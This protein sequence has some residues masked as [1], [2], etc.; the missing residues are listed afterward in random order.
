MIAI[1]SDAH[2]NL[3]AL[4]AV[5]SDISQRS[6]K[7]KIFL[8]DAVG[9]GPDPEPVLE[10][11]MEQCSILVQGNHDRAVIDPELEE[12]FNDAA[13]EAIL[14]TRSVMSERAKGF[15][16]NLPLT[17]SSKREGIDIFLVHASPRAPE[18]WNYILTLSDAHRNFYYFQEKLCFI[19]HS[20]Y[21]FVVEMTGSRQI[22]VRY[23]R[24]CK[25]NRDSRYIINA[26]SVGQP[27][28][29]D[30]RACYV[31]FNGTEV[32]F[33]RVP[34]NIELTQQKMRKAGL[35]YS[36]IERLSKGV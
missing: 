31:I 20:H 10:I 2:G 29:G 36:L 21:P 11:L 22:S 14:W 18:E 4:K 16:K 19:G 8:G 35:P 30:P 24:P 25:F 27:R 6:I 15:L 33:I 3:E 5:I 9:Y 26:G 34:Y 28:D 7:E 12:Y 32:D 13:R 23:E 1:L 17:S